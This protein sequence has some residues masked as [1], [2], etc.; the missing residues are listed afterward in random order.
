M[1]YFRMM[2]V[3]LEQTRLRT[4]QAGESVTHPACGG[5]GDAG[6]PARGWE[7]RAASVQTNP[8]GARAR[9]ARRRGVAW[10]TAYHSREPLP[11][12]VGCVKLRD[13]MAAEAAVLRRSQAG[14]AA[15]ECTD[16]GM[17]ITRTEKF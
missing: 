2:P 11:Y 8:A 9:C 13:G 12:L 7:Q 14:K 15:A 5:G 17:E 16:D 4:E 1:W 10:G 6:A 3:W